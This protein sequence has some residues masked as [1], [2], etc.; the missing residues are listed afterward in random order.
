MGNQEQDFNLPSICLLVVGDDSQYLSYYTGSLNRLGLDYLSVTQPPSLEA[1]SYFQGALWLT[2]DQVTGT[3]TQSDQA[4]LAD[5]LDGGGRLFVSGQNIGQ[6]IGS[7]S[8]YTDYLHARFV[9]PDLELYKLKGQDF[10]D[11]LVDIYIYGGDGASNQHST[12]GV[13]P[14]GEGQAVYQYWNN[15]PPDPAIYGGVAYSGTYRTVYFSFG[16]EAINRAIDRDQVLGTVLDYLGTCVPPEPP[17]AGFTASPSGERRTFQFTNTSQGTPLMSY[18]WNFGDGSPGS[19][20]ANPDHQY[21]QP[22]YYSV[23]LTVTSRFGLDMLSIIL[24]MPYEVY[25]PNVS[26]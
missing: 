8:F 15:P 9:A 4:V 11:P 1:L 16:F 3:L 21:A 17:H 24:Y 20:Q 18:A 12:D 7:S 26:K 5:Y 25:I 6:D 19:S 14:A 2:G 23:T 10:L 13:E 22:G